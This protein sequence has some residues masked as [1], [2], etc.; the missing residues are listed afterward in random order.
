MHKTI[1]TITVA[2]CVIAA[3]LTSCDDNTGSLGIFQDTDFVTTSTDK[4]TLNTRSILLDSIKA[5]SSKSYL[6][7]ITDQETGGKVTAD[8]AAQFNTMEGYSFPDKEQMVGS[9]TVDANG[10]TTD[11]ETRVVCDSCEV[12]LYFDKVYGDETNPMKVQVYMLDADNILSEDSTYYTNIDLTQYLPAGAKPIAERVFTPKDMNLS[13]SELGSSS[14][15]DNVHIVLPDSIGQRIM[16]KYYENPANF[17]DSYTFIRKVFPGLYF[18]ISNGEGTLLQ[19]EVSALNL[20]FKYMD[21]QQVGS[22]Q[23]DSIYL[24]VTRF[25][26]TPEVIQSTRFTNDQSTLAGLLADNTCSYL[27]TP[28]GICTEMT[29]PVDQI[30]AGQHATDSVSKAEVTLTRYN[31]TQT[32]N[33]FGTPQELLMVRKGE[34][35]DFFKE[36]RV[37]DRRTSY[38]TSFSPTY[39]SYTFT[40]ICRLLSYMHNEKKKAVRDVLAANGITNYTEGDAQYAAAEAQ[41]MAQHPD[42]N[43]VALIPVVTSSTT[44][45]YT[46]STI[47]TSVVHDMGLNS[48]R[49]VGGK[50]PI[51]MQ[52]VYSKF[53][54]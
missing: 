30:F 8:F 20:Y 39:N 1:K 50:D 40:N 26:A 46:G 16:E 47:Q 37:A 48:I 13:E 54:R 21:K 45:A 53:K 42:W 10:D 12:R 11:V 3:M 15:S 27:K 9:I 23:K 5:S 24:G 4:F 33:Q 31:K 17:K 52:V 2:L 44:D 51:E 19:M 25:S 7:A 36:K 34:M 14:H 35:R 41:W 6:G 38:T 49:L 29:L 28:A 18:R 22:T 32:N 43:K